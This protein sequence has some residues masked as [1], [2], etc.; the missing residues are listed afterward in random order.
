MKAIKVTYKND[1]VDTFKLACT[2]LNISQSSVIKEAMEKTIKK[3][4]LK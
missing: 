1:F 2:K 4:G 3:A